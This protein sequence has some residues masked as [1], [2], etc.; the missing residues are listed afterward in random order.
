LIPQVERAL[1]EQAQEAARTV[2]VSMETEP[3]ALAELSQDLAAFARDRAAEL[4]GRRWQDGALVDDPNAE[5]VIDE[6]TRDHIRVAISDGIRARET[7]E[8][9][10]ERLGAKDFPAFSPAR[11]KMIAR[12]EL[13]RA[14]NAGRF[15][16]MRVSNVAS[17][18]WVVDGDPCLICIENMIVGPIGL[19]ETFP[20]GDLAPPQHPNCLCVIAP[21]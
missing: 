11:A 7:A 1:A 8:Q 19:Y 16:I 17:K 5:M 6:A 21:A 20:S 13:S 3:A 15:G 9:I 2:A 10:A 12:T 4:V 18:I 14:E